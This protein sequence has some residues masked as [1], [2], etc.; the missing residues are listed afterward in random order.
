[1]SA[2]TKHIRLEEIVTEKLSSTIL[3][4]ADDELDYLN[5][6]MHV[7]ASNTSVFEANA[8]LSNGYYAG[9]G[10]ENIISL[11]SLN[12]I[13]DLN[14]YIKKVNRVLP[15]DGMF[16]CKVSPG[17]LRKKALRRTYKNGLLFN[18]VY[19]S[20]YVWHR[21]CP[22]L[23]WT[24]PIYEWFTGNKNRVYA[25]AEALGRV[26]AGGFEI[27]DYK[28][29]GTHIYFIAQ[30]TGAPSYKDMNSHGLLFKMRRISKG[31]DI[32]VFYKLRTMHLYAE[33]LQNLVYKK[34]GLKNGDKFNDDFRITASG[35]F[36]RKYW[37][38]EIPMIFNLLKGDLKLVGVRPLSNQ[39][40]SLYTKELQ[41]Y[42]IKF[43]PGLVPPYYADM[44]ESLE[45]VMD[46]EYRY[47]KSYEEK[48]FRTDFKYFLK[49]LYNIL[50]KKARSN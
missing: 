17:E 15:A 50:F 49:A 32:K 19:F 16:A 34:N 33:H 39:K 36:F 23:R 6:F 27:I 13:P 35:K 30:K 28:Q 25:L 37:I 5:S 24:Q 44:P 43:K 46:S 26:A 42:R 45:E 9:Q 12:N 8:F 4:E 48:P 38:D 41:E 22:K 3:P 18:L 11:D 29:F 1:M 14:A 7:D 2:Q 47:L 10:I 20:D 21:V 40:F 31:G